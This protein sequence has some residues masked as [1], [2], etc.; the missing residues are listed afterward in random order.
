MS[1]NGK[2]FNWF[3]L[4][5]AMSMTT[6][7]AGSRWLKNKTLLKKSQITFEGPTKLQ[8]FAATRYQGSNLGRLWCSA[9]SSQL[10]YSQLSR[11]DRK[12]KGW[13]EL[14]AFL[15]PLRICTSI[16]WLGLPSQRTNALTIETLYK[17]HVLICGHKLQPIYLL[18]SHPVASLRYVSNCT[19]YVT[20]SSSTTT[21]RLLKIH[22]C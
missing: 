2:L 21:R 5:C 9:L 14:H 12:G 1:C 11:N 3:L 6:K 19:A 13:T 20:T 16:F 8:W 10:V 18:K 17:G 22:G 4:P 7:T 15:H